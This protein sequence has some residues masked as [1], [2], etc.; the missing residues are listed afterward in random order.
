MIAEAIDAGAG[1]L[2]P[3]H[4]RQLLRAFGI[5][6]PGSHLDASIKAATWTADEIGYPVDLTLVLANAEAPDPVATGLRS[7]CLLYTSVAC[8][9]C[10]CTTNRIHRSI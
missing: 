4:G 8:H 10:H 9:A 7:A 3:R 5:A 1:T 6:A 2:S